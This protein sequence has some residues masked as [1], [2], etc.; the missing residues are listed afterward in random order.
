[1]KLGLL[2]TLTDG[3]GGGISGDGLALDLQFA[4]DKTLTA[5]R[6]PTPVFTRSS[7]DNGGTTYFGP[8]VDFD[9]VTAFSTTGISNGRASWFKSYEGTDITISYTGARWSVVTVDNGDEVTYLAAPGGEWRP[10]QA[11]WSGEAFSVTTSSTFGIV[12][13]ANNEPRFDHNPVS[14]FACRGL[15]IEESRTN[16]IT[17]SNAFNTWTLGNSTV[18]ASSV[19]TPEGTA[20]AW[21]VVED[22][23]LNIHTVTRGFTAVSGTTYTASVWLKSAENGFAFVG[24]SGGGFF[25][26]FISVN[27][28]TGAVSTALGTPIGA[29]SVSHSNGW[30]RVSFSLAATAS[31]S[32]SID[33]RLSRD[34]NW[35]NRSYLGNGVN[36]MYVYGAQVEAGS[37]PTS[38]IPTTTGTL[39]RGADVCT[40][41]AADFNRFY[42]STS[43]TLLS[44]ASIS[45]LI[46]NNRGIVQI[47]NGT[48]ES[49]L[50]HVYSFGDGGFRSIIRAGGDTP[51][52]LSTI[53]GTASTIQKRI[54][55]YEGT[56][57]ASVT[58][59]GVVATATRTMPTGLNA[60]RIGNLTDGSFYLS[61]HIAA[62]RFYKKR[63]PNAKIQALTV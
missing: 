26:T 55:A 35:A 24:L 19:V 11:D 31:L 53:L 16:A 36:G 42:N 57:F 34:G 2:N 54:I 52:V 47:D 14:P 15:L 12:K 22:S 23:L 48:N 13:A 1:M 50:R 37:F 20:D 4:A 51:T 59:G 17:G 56:S 3:R 10:D 30:W 43:G 32:S 28:S 46:G 33:I 25:P 58:N 40:I 62:I 21:K 60:M 6:G 29:S 8:L 61:G 18:A 38:Y 27:L 45:N 7:G 49:I 9:V 63:L 44:E 41:T 39:A 5:R